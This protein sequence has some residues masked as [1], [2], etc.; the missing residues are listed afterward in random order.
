MPTVGV[1][2][3]GR[4]A[5]DGDAWCGAGGGGDWRGGGVG[6]DWLVA[7]AEPVADFDGCGADVFLLSAD[8]V[9]P[10]AMM[11]TLARIQP[12]KTLVRRIVVSPSTSCG[13]P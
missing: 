3:D 1:G 13:R 5:G 8:R 12:A 2:E 11:I 9:S 6:D 7:G 10:A 4:G